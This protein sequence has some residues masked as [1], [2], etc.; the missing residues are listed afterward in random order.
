MTAFNEFKDLV[1][2]MQ[3]VLKI[4][5]EDAFIKNFNSPKDLIDWLEWRISEVK[6]LDKKYKKLVSDYGMLEE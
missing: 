6:E 2:G 1:L 3:E 4:I 5:Q